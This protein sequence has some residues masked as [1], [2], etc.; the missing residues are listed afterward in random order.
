MSV[1]I[2]AGP[3]CSGKSTFIQKNFP[4]HKIIDI[5]DFQKDFRFINIDNVMESYVQCKDALVA[6]IKE[7]ENVVLE[8]TLLKAKRRA[9]YVDAIK[10]VTD[11]PIEIYFLFPS[12]KQLLKQMKKR[13]YSKVL[14]EAQTMR[15]LAELPTV[16]EG[17]H[18]VHIVSDNP[19]YN[20]VEYA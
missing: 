12:E 18:V 20:T 16:S 7:S 1:I 4:Q 13:K 11:Q 15:E 17:Y 10:E 9:M 8:H 3:T 2:V 19:T 14:A 5:Y 6:A